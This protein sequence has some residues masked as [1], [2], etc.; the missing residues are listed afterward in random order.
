MPS[1]LKGGTT[2]FIG[3]ELYYDYASIAYFYRYHHINIGKNIPTDS[4]KL[5]VKS[6][7][8][9]IL[10]EQTFEKI[11]LNLKQFYLYR[12]KE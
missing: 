3:K 4:G 2:L 1:T 8:V 9:P 7:E 10:P 5:I 12:K 6:R 11:P